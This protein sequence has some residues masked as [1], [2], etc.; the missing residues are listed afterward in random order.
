MSFLTQ[1]V[2]EA[3]GKRRQE[4][5]RGKKT[6]V[7][8]M[9]SCSRLVYPILKRSWRASTQMPPPREHWC[10]PSSWSSLL[11]SQEKTLLPLSVPGAIS[12]PAAPGQFPLRHY[13]LGEDQMSQH[14]CVTEEG[15]A[16]RT[17]QCWLWSRLPCP[18]AAQLRPW[19]RLP[20]RGSTVLP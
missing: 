5:K 3:E 2:K 4:R 1:R 10:K 16:E 15:T 8:G 12:A 11:P 13:L 17:E 19:A 20:R 14:M 7:T 9:S 6:G 18:Q